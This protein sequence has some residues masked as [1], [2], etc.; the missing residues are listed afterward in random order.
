MGSPGIASFGAGSNQ[1][2]R[3]GHSVLLRGDRP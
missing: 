2:N 3:D 1:V